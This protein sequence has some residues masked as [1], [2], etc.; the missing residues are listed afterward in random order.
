MTNLQEDD[1]FQRSIIMDDFDEYIRQ[2]EP[3]QKEKSQNWQTAIGLQ[4]VDGLKPS[5]YLIEIAKANIEGK[6]T[7]NEVK[8]RIESYY[9]QQTGRKTIEGDRTEEAD[10]V[11]ANIT[12][13]LSE[14]TFTC[15]PAELLSI[16]KRLFTG[17]KNIRVKVGK[18]LL[19]KEIHVQLQF[20]PLNTF[21]LLA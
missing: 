17:V 2:G 1:E 3:S 21:A 6:I 7:I 9:K 19:A 8:Y 16:H 4:Q 11:S 12:E 18:I 15:S 10:K 14:K 13:I 20:L 5:A